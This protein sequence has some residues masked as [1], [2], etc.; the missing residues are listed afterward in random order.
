MDLILDGN[1]YSTAGKLDAF[2]QLHVARKLSPA[3]GGI[4]GLVKE[5]NADKDKSI[6]TVISLSYL[7]D[8]DVEFII[9]KC[10]GTVVRR[11][12]DGK[13]ARVQ[14]NDGKLMFDDITMSAL[15]ELT[16]A[17]IEENMGDFFRT[18]LAGV[19]KA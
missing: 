1:H 14:T 19:K 15:L 16:L 2:S 7:P 10:L 17:V 13:P 12:S 3:L 9:K 4:E 5:E 6:L 18:G 8:A 11:S